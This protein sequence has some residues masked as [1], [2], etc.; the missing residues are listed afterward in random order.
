MNFV[1]DDPTSAVFRQGA[2]NRVTE[3]IESDFLSRSQRII[4]D[5]V[6]LSTGVLLVGN[7]CQ[8]PHG[9]LSLGASEGSGAGGEQ[10]V[11]ISKSETKPITRQSGIR[12]RIRCAKLV[13]FAALS[14]YESIK[15]D[16]HIHAVSPSVASVPDVQ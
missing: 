15:M 14:I 8:Q 4:T 10:N 1:D 11:K 3:E 5:A 6:L 7:K 13:Q 9:D 2:T 12:L 16:T